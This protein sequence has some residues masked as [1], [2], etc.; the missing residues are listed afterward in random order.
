MFMAVAMACGL[1]GQN[2]Q[3]NDTCALAYTTV[4]ITTEMECTYHLAQMID[5]IPEP[6]YL[7]YAE[8]LSLGSPRPNL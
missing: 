8:C 6:A 5:S 3:M 2:P 1:L 4:P 7:V